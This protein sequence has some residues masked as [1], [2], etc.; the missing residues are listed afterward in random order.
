M[1]DKLKKGDLVITPVMESDYLT[2]KKEYEIVKIFSDNSF[3][4]IDDNGKK[5]YCKPLKDGHL[6]GLDWDFKR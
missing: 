3:V 2:S 4:I 6:N 5:L 1:I